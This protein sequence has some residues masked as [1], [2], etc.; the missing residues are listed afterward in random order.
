M[1]SEQTNQSSQDPTQITFNLSSTLRSLVLTSK[2]STIGLHLLRLNLLE[3][4]ENLVN[5]VSSRNNILKDLGDIA[6]IKVQL[7][8]DL[9]GK[10]GHEGLE[11]VANEV[12]Q[13]NGSVANRSTELGVSLE[14]SPRLS[15]LQVLVAQAGNLHCPLQTGLQMGVVHGLVV[16][17]QQSV[18]VLDQLDLALGLGSTGRH[19]RAHTVEHEG[20]AAVDEVT[21]VL[22][23]L[24]VV[25]VGQVLPVEGGVGL[26]G[27]VG[28]QVEAPDLRGN[29]GL[30]GLITEHAGILALAEL[31]V[32]VVEV[33]RAGDLTDQRPGVVRAHQRAGEDDGVEGDVVLAHE[34]HQTDLLGVAPPLLPLLG[35]V[36][37]DT[38]IADRGIE[39]H[40]EH[41]VLVALQGHGSSPLQV[42]GDATRLETVLDPAV[43]DVDGVGRPTVLDGGLSHPLL[44]LL[45]LLGQVEEEVLGGALLHY[46]RRTALL[47]EGVLQLGGVQEVAAF[48]ALI[49]SGLLI[50]TDGASSLDET[51]SQ[52]TLALVAVDLL[53][54]LLHQLVLFMQTLENALGNDSLLVN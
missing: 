4:G 3:N 33:L 7:V 38:D 12:N 42:T 5:L 41:L 20:Q 6:V 30:L 27:A 35:V 34:L 53:D 37:G 2:L 51:I 19:G 40:I 22:Q 47:A 25:L 45:S 17:L 31:A 21:Q 50:A 29:A 1:L 54:L 13:V 32:L 52:E 28:E 49:T 15:I 14:H 46:V 24:V 18:H 39:P 8:A 23:Q 36:G 44:E 43:G 26:F 10:S 16:L 11:D 9:I 48:I